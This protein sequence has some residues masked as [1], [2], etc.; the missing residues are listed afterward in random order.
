MRSFARLRGKLTRN[1]NSRRAATK[2]RYEFQAAVIHILVFPLVFPPFFFFAILRPPII[3]QIRILSQ[4]NILRDII[5]D[6]SIKIARIESKMQMSVFE[7][8]VLRNNADIL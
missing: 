6:E 5:I 3:T 2:P 1:I 7:D 8:I 4:T